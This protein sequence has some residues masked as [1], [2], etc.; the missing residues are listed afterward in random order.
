MFMILLVTYVLGLLWYRLSDYILHTIG[1]DED[2]DYY[3]VVH[4]NLRYHW[5]MSDLGEKMDVVERVIVSMYYMLT[6][7][8]TV[9]FGDL[10]PVSISE[11]A[12]GSAV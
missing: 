1:P 6:T 5:C 7:L 12:V 2:D 9:G 10:H 3:W 4:N 8:S 11:K